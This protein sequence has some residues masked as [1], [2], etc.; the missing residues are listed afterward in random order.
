MFCTKPQGTAWWL[1]R[2]ASVWCSR[3]LTIRTYKG[4]RSRPSR[5]RSHT[6]TR[7]LC[8]CTSCTTV[9]AQQQARPHVCEGWSGKCAS[10]PLLAIH[11]AQPGDLSMALT[12]VKSYSVPPLM[13]LCRMELQLLLKSLAP[14]VASYQT[15]KQLQQQQRQSWQRRGKRWRQQQKRAD[16]PVRCGQS[17]ARWRLQGQT[18]AM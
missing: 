3:V 8:H 18:S 17:S 9:C 13:L 11:G 14:Q 4:H 12:Y 16:H 2:Q 10:Q 15:S 6:E 7:H 5:N 1:S